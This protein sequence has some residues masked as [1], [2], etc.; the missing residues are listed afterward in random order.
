MN[1]GQLTTMQKMVTL[2]VF[3]LLQFSILKPH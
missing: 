2:S 3:V 1:V